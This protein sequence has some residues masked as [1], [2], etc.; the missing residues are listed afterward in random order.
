MSQPIILTQLNVYPI[1]SCGGISLQTA[2]LE[3]RGLKHD[4]RWMI[5]DEDGMFMT[6]RDYPRM[7]LIRV[8]VMSDHLAVVAPN[9]K[10][11]RV[12]FHLINHTEESVVV[13]GDTV[14]AVNVSSEAADWFSEFLGISCRLVF[15][16]DHLLRPVEKTYT[17]LDSIVGFSDAYPFLMISEAS[18]ENLNSRMEHRLPMNRFRP[19]LVVAGCEPFAEDQWRL[20]RIGSIEFHVVKP[21]ER[22]AITTVDQAT[23]IRGKEPLRT[24]SQ[25][26]ERNGKVLFG[27]NL[28]HEQKG[29]LRVGEEVVVVR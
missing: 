11:L 12:P 16:P 3:E 27:Q 28:I 17:S 24:L 2:Q 13:W 4:R 22:C 7:A 23:G 20:I 8:R 21:C 29:S 15:M 26:R 14:T 10:E 9:T 1:K 6:Q 5:V 19:N 18:L 25:F